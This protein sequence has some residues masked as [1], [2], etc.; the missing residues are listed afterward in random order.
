MRTASY[1][2]RFDSCLFFIILII[3]VGVFVRTVRFGEVPPPLS[4]DEAWNGMDAVKTLKEGPLIFYPNNFGREPLHI[5]LTALS[6]KFLGST[7]VAVRLPSLLLGSLAL[8]VCYLMTRE[9]F[10]RRVALWA[11][12]V[13]AITVWP[14]HA[15]RIGVRPIGLPFFSGLAIWQVAK[16]YKTRRLR[17]W[18][19]GGLFYGAAFYTYLSVRFTPIAVAAFLLYLIVTRQWCL[20]RLLLY[21]GLACIVASAITVMPLGIY[22]ITNPDAFVARTAQTSILSPA[23]S[24]GETIAALADSILRVLGMFNIQGD[25]TA[26]HNIPYRPMFDIITGAAF[27]VGGYESFRRFRQAEYAFVL[28]WVAVMLGPTILTTGAPVFPRAAGIWPV[29]AILPALGLDRIWDACAGGRRLGAKPVSLAMGA[30]MLAS[31]SITTYDYFIRYDQMDEVKYTFRD[32][33]VQ[34]AHQINSF[35][36]TGWTRGAIYVIEKPARADRRVYVDYQLWKEWL[37]AHF[38]VPLSPSFVVPGSG[39]RAGTLD[40][41]AVPTT[42]YSWWNPDYPGFWL[43]EMNLLP[44]NSKIEMHLGPLTK[45]RRAITTFPEPLPAYIVFTA[46]PY[47]TPPASMARFEP[48]FDL[49]ESTVQWANG[50]LRV[51]LAWLA[52]QSIPQDYTVF[53]HAE[54]DGNIVAQH[55]DGPMGGCPEMVGCFPM[56]QWRPGDIVVDDLEFT[57]PQTWNPR[58]NRVWMGA[59]HWSDTQRVGITSDQLKVVEGRVLLFPSDATR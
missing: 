21:G 8:P 19:L 38:L 5:W 32:A 4:Y 17:H 40:K 10:G 36:E 48:G 49:V 29:M 6:I 55:D 15:S 39:G 57:L 30:A 52:R 51:H 46:A 43:P 50:R 42:L 54:Q 13:M 35:L 28:I 14:I 3:A 2:P 31:L 56:T 11:L 26:S 33:G 37:P 27:L 59:Y 24:P 20:N 22:F 47:P 16:G 53:V 34:L 44:R 41:A 7:P 1:R 45:A 18:I 9:L 23:T 58:H 25:F 12:I